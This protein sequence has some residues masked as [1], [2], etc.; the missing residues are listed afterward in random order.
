MKTSVALAI[1]A[2]IIGGV[3]VVA[4]VSYWL[5]HPRRPGPA[6]YV[7]LSGLGIVLLS[8]SIL[9]NRRS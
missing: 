3:V 6:A 7:A 9:A 4:E 2:A 5:S 1:A 8:I